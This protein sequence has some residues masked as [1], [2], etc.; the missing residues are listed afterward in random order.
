MSAMR[1]ARRR[2]RTWS[3]CS[4]NSR[5]SRISGWF[6]TAASAA[7]SRRARSGASAA[8]GCSAVS[9]KKRRADGLVH[10]AV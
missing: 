6:A 1:L 10:G 3:V 4:S 7:I 2:G 5:N 9:L 8:R